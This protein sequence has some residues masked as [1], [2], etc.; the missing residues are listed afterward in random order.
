MKFYCKSLP[1]G[2]LDAN[3]PG[4]AP[5]FTT[6]YPDVSGH[7]D[8]SRRNAR[9]LENPDSS[10]CRISF[11]NAAKIEGR[12][13]SVKANHVLFEKDLPIIHPS[14]GFVYFFIRGTLRIT[15]IRPRGA[16]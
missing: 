16:L 4:H 9:R 6:K 10:V 8:D 14:S 15:N 1:T 12:S 13:L 2:M 3:L 7:S 11:C 5:L